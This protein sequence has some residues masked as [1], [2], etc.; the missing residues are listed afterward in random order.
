MDN[1]YV[2]MSELRTGINLFGMMNCG[3]T[4]VG[5]I[6]AVRYGLSFVDTDVLIAELYGQKPGDIIG[7]EGPEIFM[8]V[9]REIL[10]DQPRT[11][12][13][14][15]ATGGAVAKDEELV[16]HLGLSGVG[17]FLFVAPGILEDRTKPEDIAKLANP[18]RLS[19]RDLY[20]VERM[21]FYEAA[22]DLTIEVS[23]PSELEDITAERV[24]VAVETF[25]AA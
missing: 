19:Y 12:A 23:D 7:E 9:Q 11:G 2:I 3:K 1:S 5:G 8:A 25:V 4:T 14:I 16:R 10:M 15:W 13:E 17:V 6:L 20:L 22:A 21:P 24:A 18:K